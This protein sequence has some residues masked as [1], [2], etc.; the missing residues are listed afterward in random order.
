MELLLAAVLN[1]LVKNIIRLTDVRCTFHL[2]VISMTTWSYSSRSGL[3]KINSNS[4]IKQ[5]GTTSLVWISYSMSLQFHIIQN[6]I[7]RLR[8]GMKSNMALQ[9]RLSLGESRKDYFAQVVHHESKNYA[10]SPN[11][12]FINL[13]KLRNTQ[14]CCMLQYHNINHKV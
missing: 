1:Q 9:L 7:L 11:M 12:S 14:T 10:H 6:V 4:L 5:T 3:H 13:S 2:C 8:L